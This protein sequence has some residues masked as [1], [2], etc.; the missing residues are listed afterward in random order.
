MRRL[1]PVLSVIFGL[2]TTVSAQVTYSKEISRIYQAKC[3][4]CHRDGDITPFALNNYQDAL[5]WGRD[6]QNSLV[7]GTMP[8]WK[9]V[10]GYGDFK[11]PR[12][13]TDDEKQTILDWMSNGMPEGDPA[14]LPPPVIS[15]SSWP[16]GQPDFGLAMPQSFTPDIGND[17]YRCFVIPSGMA[18]DTDMSAIDFIPGNRQIVHHI[19]LYQDT[20]GQSQML[21]GADGQPGYTCFGGPGVDVN[22]D[23]AV[24]A[25]WAPGQRTS[26]LPDG[27]GITVKKGATLIMQVHYSPAAVTGPDQTQV[28]LYRAT[29]KIQRHLY[30]IPVVDEDFKIPAGSDNYQH[31]T[32]FQIPQIALAPHL[33]DVHAIEI[34]P[35]MHLLG[36]DIKVNVVHTDQSVTPM[37]WEDN[38]DF[39]WQ[40]YYTYTQPMAITSGSGVQ[41]TCTWD[42]SDNNPSN[43]N[44]PL[45]DVTWGERTRDEMC[46]AFVGVTFDN[47][48]LLPAGFLGQF[49]GAK[50]K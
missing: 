33:L 4:T 28:G 1:V 12:N 13:L 38:W 23:T 11:D 9:P 35:H 47:E 44:N 21:D 10:P 50:K 16:L 30:E 19:I 6:I 14:D 40:G 48:P 45:V 34:Y 26:L 25:G 7:T 39:R 41:L 49:M 43:P 46:V 27:I 15:N 20:T 29:S 31:G 18:A 5:T 42:N 2:G 36:R 37:I 22:F 32:T 24:L 17:V 8:P 3:A